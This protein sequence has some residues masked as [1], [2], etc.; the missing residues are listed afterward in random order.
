MKN[1]LKKWNELK[2]LFVSSVK[3]DTD[4]PLKIQQMINA[5]IEDHQIDFNEIDDYNSPL[6]Q[7]PRCNFLI[8]RSGGC[9]YYCC[10]NCHYEFCWACLGDFLK[11]HNNHHVCTHLSINVNN[12]RFPVLNGIDYGNDKKSYPIP[13][14]FEKQIVFGRWSQLRRQHQKIIDSNDS[15]NF[16][17]MKNNDENDVKFLIVQML[18]NENGQMNENEKKQRKS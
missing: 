1:A 14:D 11:D 9:F 3:S 15:L 13:F 7:C 18:S 16:I 2:E 5:S 10:V 6:K 17:F 12:D 4:Y 8:Y